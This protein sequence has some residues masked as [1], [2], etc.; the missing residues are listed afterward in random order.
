MLQFPA[1]MQQHPTSTLAASSFLHLS[2]WPLLQNDDVQ[3]AMEEAELEEKWA[4]IRNANSNLPVLGRTNVDN[5]QEDV[6]GEPED[7]EADNAEES[8][9]DDFEQETG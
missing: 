8:D 7:E 3:L 9:A 2:P 4:E 6:E 1:F 5:D